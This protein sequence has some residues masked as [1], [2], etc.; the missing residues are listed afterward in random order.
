[1]GMTVGVMVDVMTDAMN[2]MIEETTRGTMIRERTEMMT[3]ERMIEETRGRAMT[4]M[5]TSS[6][7]GN[8]SAMK[9]RE[10]SRI[11]PNAKKNERPRRR[12]TKRKSGKFSKS[13]TSAAG[14][15]KTNVKGRR[16]RNAKKK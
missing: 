14:R 2:A 5:M 12:N 9:M 13:V 11:G 6:A 16:M 4:G 1:M 3:E 15:K 8:A 7:V 10:E